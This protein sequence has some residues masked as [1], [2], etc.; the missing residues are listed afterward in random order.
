MDGGDEVG[1]LA[2]ADLQEHEEA[3][4]AAKEQELDYLAGAVL[5]LVQDQERTTNW[6]ATHLIENHKDYTN[7]KSSSL[8][9]K[10]RAAFTPFKEMDEWRVRYREQ[11]VGNGKRWITAERVKC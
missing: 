8:A 3:A 10:I 4:A 9:E 1:V 7:A 6:L 5:P 2:L 11:K